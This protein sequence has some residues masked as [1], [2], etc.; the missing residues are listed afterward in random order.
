MKRL[1]LVLDMCLTALIYLWS[2]WGYHFLID[3]SESHFETYLAFLPHIVILQG[4]FLSYF[5][6]YKSFRVI[7]ILTYERIVLTAIGLNMAILFTMLFLLKLQDYSRMILLAFA[8]IDFTALVIVRYALVW[9]YF[10]RTV[11]KGENY[12]QVL[13]IGTGERAARLSEALRQSRDWGVDIIGHLDRDESKVGTNVLGAPVLGTVGAISDI[14]EKHVVDEVI[15]AIPRKMIGDVEAIAYACEDEGVNFR[16]MADIYD[17][18]LAR[19]RLTELDDI[20]LLSFEP[21]AQNEAK[22]L[23]KRLMDLILTLGAM[24]LLIPV[25]LLVAIAIK[26]DSPGPVFFIQQRVGLRKRVFPM[27]KFRTMV[28]DSEALMK[29]LESQN[30]AE[31]LF[32]KWPMIQ[33]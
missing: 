27:Y 32:L 9:W 22:L 13:I 14:L 5:G 29:E 12:L 8:V 21:V 31:V 18:Q 19:M 3:N 10:K 25:M 24:P 26:L 20:P 33:G 15:M 6:A 17:L 2:F 7:S 4:F 16:L 30:E 1:L 11:Q 28:K 23:V